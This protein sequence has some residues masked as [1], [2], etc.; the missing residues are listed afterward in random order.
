LVTFLR[1]NMPSTADEQLVAAR[2]ELAEFRATSA[3]IEHELQAALED[4][5][6]EAKVLAARLTDAEAK[7]KKLTLETNDLRAELDE[8]RQKAKA[9]RS[10]LEDAVN[11]SRKQAAE[12]S[13]V[14]RLLR[15]RD[16]DLEKL[17]RECDGALETAILAETTTEDLRARVRELEGKLMHVTEERDTAVIAATSAPQADE[18][19]PGADGGATSGRRRRAS[20]IAALTPRDESFVSST[21]ATSP[22]STAEGAGA[23]AKTASSSAADALVVSSDLREVLELLRT[24]ALECRETRVKL[25]SRRA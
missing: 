23:V 7:A 11:D 19:V 21:V 14:D 17:Q 12:L 16:F 15:Q 20:L 6:R 13:R 4:K 1:D 3:E 24:V 22:G 10:K 25:T 2:Q 9:Q 8:E 5:E 18:Y